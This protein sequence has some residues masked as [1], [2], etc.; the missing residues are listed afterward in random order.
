MDPEQRVIQRNIPPLVESH[1]PVT[2]QVPAL[3]YDFGML[4]MLYLVELL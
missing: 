2:C 1:S 4:E 3:L